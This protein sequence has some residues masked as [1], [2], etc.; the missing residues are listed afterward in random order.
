MSLLL[1]SASTYY[2][3]G[4]RGD[5]NKVLET[6]GKKELFFH[7]LSWGSLRIEKMSFFIDFCTSLISDPQAAAF[8]GLF[9]SLD[10]S[11]TYEKI[12]D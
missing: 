7:V 10:F 11:R 12:W 6:K 2:K 3:Y 1:V 8:T 9:Y 4:G 5:R